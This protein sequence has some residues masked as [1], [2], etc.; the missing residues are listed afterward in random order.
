MIALLSAPDLLPFMG[1]MD[2]SFAALSPIK[3]SGNVLDVAIIDDRGTILISVDNIHKP[4]SI[5]E[6]RDSTLE[7]R[8]VH[9]FAVDT[10]GELKWHEISGPLVEGINTREARDIL[11]DPEG[12]KE[13]QA[14]FNSL[15]WTSH[16]KKWVPGQEE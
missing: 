7:S 15:Y 3:V 16:L 10:D 9:C 14:V 2:G 5:K 12:R 11:A 4:G 13:I 1:R 8:V 6:V